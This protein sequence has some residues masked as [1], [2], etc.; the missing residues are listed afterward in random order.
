MT[1]DVDVPGRPDTCTAPG[2][3]RT[4]GLHEDFESSRTTD[5][6]SV[7]DLADNG[8]TW[9]FGDL[10]GRGNLTGGSGRFAIV[11][12]DHYGRDGTQ[13]TALVSPSVDLGDAEEP[14]LEFATDF[15]RYWSTSAEVD[16]SVDGGET[17]SNVWRDFDGQAGP[18]TI[19]LPVPA[20][21]GQDDVRVRFHYLRA[22]DDW[23]WQVDDVFLGEP[24]CAPAEGGLVVGHTRSTVTRKPLVGVE[25]KG[26]RS[27]LTATSVR[28][29][30]DD[31]TPDGLYWLFT[32]GAG[33]QRLT[34]TLAAHTDADTRVQVPDSETVRQDLGLESGRLEP[35]PRSL[36]VEVRAGKVAQRRVTL[37]NTGDASLRYDLEEVPGR[38]VT[39]TG[40]GDEWER[41]TPY[42]SPVSDSAA[43]VL[44]G[45]IYSFGGVGYGERARADGYR[46]DEAAQ[47][48]ERLAD[49]PL[50]HRK[51]AGGFVDGRFVVTGGWGPD[52]KP[53]D[54]TSVY[55]PETDAWTEG[56]ANPKPWAAAGSRRPGRRAVRRGRL[57]RERRLR[58]HGRAP[59][60]PSVR[61][62]DPGR[63]LSPADC[64]GRVRHHR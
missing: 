49:L 64:L 20:A 60:R 11:D 14:V 54:A 58:P 30:D 17:W 24:T 15:R 39:A 31:G 50:A 16:V 6:W 52:D 32:P 21:A 63:R 29:P 35:V 53:T 19:R 42:P 40:A 23:W 61:R 46:Y 22:S 25:V 37:A 51:P 26:A 13:N 18:G 7:E 47:K 2:Y 38:P 62:V 12:S 43:G 59:L 4:G 36:T 45:T 9:A 33:R 28:T 27:P 1:H 56:A 55:D 57:R 48:W 5:R 34:A 41:V 44:D 3:A 8:Q 10:G